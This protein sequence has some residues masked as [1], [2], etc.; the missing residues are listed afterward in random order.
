MENFSP[1]DYWKGI[2][3]Y[4]LNAATYKMALA[5]CLLG[6]AKTGVDEVSWDQVAASFYQEYQQRLHE[7]PMPQMGTRGRRTVLERIVQEEKSG[8]ISRP[9][10]IEKVC[11]EGLNDVVPRF[12]TIGA[13]KL[14]QLR[15]SHVQALYV[16]RLKTGRLNGPGGLSRRTVHHIHR[17]LSKALSVAVRQELITI[18]PCDR[19]ETV[20]PDDAEVL[21]LSDEQT[22]VMFAAAA[23]SRSPNLYPLVVLAVASGMRRGE[24]LALQ[25]KD[26]DLDASVLHVKASLSDTSKGVSL[27]ETKTKF[28]KR[29][30]HLPAFAV[31][32]LSAHRAKQSEM[33]LHLGVRA[34]DQR[35]V[36]ES[37]KNDRFGPVRPRAATEMF[38]RFIAKVDVPRITLHGLRH[39]AATSALR[40]GEN[41]LAVSRRLGHVKASITLDTYG[42]A[43]PG[44]DVDIAANLDGRLAAFLA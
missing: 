15:T 1:S 31:E 16:S 39:T 11:I 29:S 17:C 20:K 33:R 4:G 13:T 35:F 36:F 8:L 14:Q 22:A 24:M 28:S 2:V 25:W 18:N 3:L 9:Q 38:S 26:V 5:K 19:A 21:S 10:A 32:N 44:D 37:L 7:N 27:K 12:Q 42:H 40:A 30:I 41:I 43:I 23:E 34:D 6:F